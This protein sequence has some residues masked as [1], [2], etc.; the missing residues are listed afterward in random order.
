MKRRSEGLVTNL[1]STPTSGVGA[2]RGALASMVTNRRSTLASG[3]GAGNPD[4]FT[5]WL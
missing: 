2:L 4:P 5:F 1:G 3:A